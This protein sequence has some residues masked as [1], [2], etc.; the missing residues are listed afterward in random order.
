MSH[1]QPKQ[2]AEPLSEDELRAQTTEPLPDREVMSTLLLAP[3]P[4]T[5]PPPAFIDGDGSQAVRA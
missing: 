4:G 2:E 1:E 5:I 3:I